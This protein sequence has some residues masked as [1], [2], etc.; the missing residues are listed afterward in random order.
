MS[1]VPSAPAA[2]VS[3]RLRQPK[4]WLRWLGAVLALAG[5]FVSWELVRASTSLA[6]APLVQALCGGAE[7]GDDCTAVLTSP[8]AYVRVSPQPE[9][10]RVPVAAF[11]MM[12]FAAVALWYLFVGPPTRSGRAWHFPLL[13]L[14]LY[15]AWQSADYIRIM[16]VVLHRWCGGCLAAHALNAGL[17]IVTLLAWPWRSSSAP[18]PRHPAA[19][20]ALATAT[21]GLI[22]V[23]AHLGWLYFAIASQ[24]AQRRQAEYAAVLDDPEFLLWDFR[25]QP[26]VEIPVATDEPFAGN[27]DAPHTIVVFGDFQCEACRRSHEV[28]TQVAARYGDRVRVAFRHHPQDPACNPDPRYRGAAHPSACRA[29]QA[30]EAAGLVGGRDAYLAMRKLMWERQAQLPRV[31]FAQQTDAQRRLFEEWAGELGLERAAFSA[32]LESPAVAERIRAD[33]ELARALKLQA[34]PALFL[35]GK[36]LRGWSRLETWDALLGPR[37]AESAPAE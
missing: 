31:P 10:P 1:D 37:A 8:Q 29:A 36:R 11:G 6:A 9:A 28:L 32:A 13:V 16:A 20:L 26:V 4:P 2:P 23:V 25:R 30:A 12:Y 19:R 17:L 21:A 27:P 15:A 34:M 3:L 18:A 5:W 35:D 7:A 33:L 14:V 22:A 24:V